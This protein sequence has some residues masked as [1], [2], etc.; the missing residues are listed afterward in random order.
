MGVPFGLAEIDCA[1][2][3]D[4]DAY[5]DQCDTCDDNPSND[6]VQDCTGVWGGE[7]Y[8]DD[9]FICDIDPENEINEN[10]YG[11]CVKFNL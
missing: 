5:V 11:N 6:C 8:L 7:A 9:C 4:G 2:E 1:G 10:L 3:C